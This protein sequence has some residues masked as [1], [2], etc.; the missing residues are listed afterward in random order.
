MRKSNF[1]ADTNMTDMVCDFLIGIAVVI[2][3]YLFFGRS[4]EFSRFFCYGFAFS[5]IFILEKKDAG[6]Y[7]RTRFFYIDRTIKKVTFSWMVAGGILLLCILPSGE[8]KQDRKALI[9]CAILFYILF[10]MIAL[11]RRMQSQ[12]RN[13]TRTLLVG[14][15][16]EYEKFRHFLKKTNLNL[17]IVGYV[18]DGEEP[19]Y[20]GTMENLE[21]LIREY[22]VEQVFFMQNIKNQDYRGQIALCSRMGVSASIVM[23]LYQSNYGDSYVN[24]LGTYPVITYHTVTLNV[25]KRSIKRSMDIIG[26]LVG[27][28]LSSPIML[29]A[30]I[31]IKLDS[32]GPVIFKQTR[33]GK[34]GRHFTIYKFRTMCQDAEKK[35]AE[36]QKENEVKS[37]LMFK[38]ENDPRI[39]K[40]GAF[41]RK[42]SID[43]LPQLFNVLSGDMSL[44]GPRPER[45]EIIAEYQKEMPEFV[46]RTRVKAGVTGFA[47][48]YGKYNTVPYDKLK[49]DLFYIENYS[50][51]MDLK[52]I[53]MTVKTVLKKDSTEGVDTDQTTGLKEHTEGNEEVERKI[54]EY[55]SREESHH[56]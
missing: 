28:I 53:L 51:W 43:E 19:E 27:I 22:A 31:A 54:Q 29:I 3:S 11:A 52:L 38:M 5:V 23:D 7:D 46:F 10:V 34:N 13:Q 20:V 39:T 12:N 33:V 2:L 30:A 44:V 16:E 14:N 49:L 40:V 47:Q 55:T 8:I 18:G 50:L 42:T 48:I 1:E 26:S 4:G 9:F 35:K 32:P 6:L 56:E 41:L 24:A 25:Y 17:N 37:D 15:C 36:L 21:E 45:P